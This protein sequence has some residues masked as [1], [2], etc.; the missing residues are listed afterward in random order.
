MVFTETRIPGVVIVDIEP[1]P[2]ARG[3]FARCYCQREFEEYGL[4]PLGIQCNISQNLR[5][6]TLRGMHFQPAPNGEPKLVRCNRGR[7]LDLVADIRPTSPTYGQHIPI[8]LTAANHRAV[9]IPADCAHGFQTLE[10]DT[11]VLYLM[12]RAY[13]PG[14]ARGFRFDD[15]A[16]SIEWPLAVS[17]ISPQ[18]LAWPAFHE[19]V[20]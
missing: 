13:S 10:D 20:E 5:K 8:E 3:F 19:S 2:D 12:G 15:P 4:P 7:I 18:D 11:E 6:G 1:R 16:F 9:F 14:F 17:S